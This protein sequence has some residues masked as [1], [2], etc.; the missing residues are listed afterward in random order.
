M[1]GES[2][3]GKGRLGF[4]ARVRAER[5]GKLGDMEGGKGKGKSKEGI[6]GVWGMEGG[7]EVKRI[8]WRA[9]KHK[10]GRAHV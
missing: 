2:G 9:E 1:G 5:G 7:M 3:G 10:I 4:G 6:R 8:P